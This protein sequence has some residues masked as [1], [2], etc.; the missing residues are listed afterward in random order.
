MFDFYKQCFK[1]SIKSLLANKGRSFLTMLGITIGV[2]AVIIIMAVGAGAQGL[3]LNQIKSFGVNMIG[4]LPGASDDNGPPASVMGIV[5]TTLT[6]EDALALNDKKNVPNIVNA[7]AYY[8]TVGNASWGSNS[9]DTNLSGTTIG[10]L[11]VEDGEVGQGR[12]F[13][14]EEETNLSKVAVLGS[15]AKKELFG[16]SDPIGQK[17]KIKKHN[18]EI[19]GVMKEKGT[20]ALQNND[21]QIFIPIKT[22]QK[23]IAG[24]NHASMIRLKVDN[25]ENVDR[26]MG[27]IKATLRERH[28]ISDQSGDNDDFTVRSSAQAMEMITTITDA[29]KF[30]LAAI[31]AMSLLVGG[32]GIMNIMLISVTERTKEI[33]LRKAVGA[34][35]KNIMVQFLI[36]AAVIT[37][38]G[39]AIGVIIGSL[40]AVFISIIINFLGYDWNLSISLLSIALALS[41]S[42]AVGF[43][44]GLYP[45][46]KASKLQPVEALRHE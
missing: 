43:I 28:D 6:Y 34:N 26:A 8:K 46:R 2:S 37:F 9:Y 4:I 5:V 12:F 27:D 39:G 20:V 30:F 42:A 14:K 45:A 44:F 40:V 25:V 7:V 32:I 22:M 13:T 3:I 21:D 24:V 17:I 36:E 41:V 35:N 18:L 31:A 16:D 29:L 38:G 10:Y 23:L 11:D 19:I 1:S 15:V 33:G